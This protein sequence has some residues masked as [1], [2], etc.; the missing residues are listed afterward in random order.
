MK[1]DILLNTIPPTPT[2]I[3]NQ[4]RGFRK[5]TFTKPYDIIGLCDGIPTKP[6]ELIGFGVGHDDARCALII[7]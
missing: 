6:F 1:K 7:M 4:F 3:P 2:L 5:G